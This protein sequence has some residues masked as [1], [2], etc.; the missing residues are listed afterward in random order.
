M[1]IKPWIENPF[2]LLE[3]YKIIPSISMSKSERLNTITRLIFLVS[4]IMFILKYPYTLNFLCLSVIIILILYFLTVKEHYSEMSDFPPK[5]KYPL[6]A[7]HTMAD[8]KM[9]VEPII[10][11]RAHDASVW[12]APS[13]RHSAVNSNNAGYDI[14]EEYSSV[15]QEENY[16]EFDP[17]LESYTNF[18]LDKL[19]TVCNNKNMPTSS[20][21]NAPKSAGA[22]NLVTTKPSYLSQGQYSGIPKQDET[23]YSL[24]GMT[25]LPPKGTQTT[26]LQQLQFQ[27]QQFD[28][29]RQM[30]NKEG[31]VYQNKQ[32]NPRQLQYQQNKRENFTT[33]LRVQSQQ[34]LKNK[35]QTSSSDYTVFKEDESTLPSLPPQDL[36][37]PRTITSIYGDGVVSNEERIKY[38]ENIEPNAYSYSDVAYPINSNLG[39]SYTPDIPPM[40]LD[41]VTTP[42]GT[43]PLFH[44]I[45]PQLIRSQGIPIERREELPYRNAWSARYSGFDA[46]PGTV[47]FED[48]YDPRFTGYGD[49]YR[50]YLDTDGNVQYY[51]SDV[52]AY[53]APNFGIRSKVDFIDFV[54]PMGRV[55]PEYSRSVG[56]SDV[57]QSVHDQFNSDALF[58]REGLQER[59][60]KKKNQEQWQQRAR[61]FSKGAHTSSF[62]SN[63]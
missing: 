50:G 29:S 52:D 33:P 32:N 47:N 58:F 35:Y 1:S 19:G 28:Q 15:P 21:Y 12:S 63:Y 23:Q 55:L 11:P 18:N 16:K 48:I 9:S 27:P 30:G 3:S 6:I 46:A 53:R 44:R 2:S 7:Q 36:L 25:E 5:Y 37:I 13:Y 8:K 41:Q 57:K 17:R 49:E 20:P 39:I 56:L 59:L 38:L 34:P 60:M 24:D 51:Y 42:Q 14:S 22:G 26:P 10:I 54:D 4:V 40:V 45:D 62:T 43:Y 31:F 61:P